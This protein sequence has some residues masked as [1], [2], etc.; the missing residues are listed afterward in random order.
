MTRT[1]LRVAL[2]APL[3]AD[4]AAQLVTLEPRIEIHDQHSTADALFGLPPEG[5]E[6]IAEVVSD[7]PRLRWVHGMASG[8]AAEVRRAGL[9]PAQIDRVRFTTSAGPH[10][11]PL[12]EFALLCLLAGAKD[13]PRLQAQQRRREWAPPWTMTHLAQATVAVVGLGH[14]GRECARAVQ[15]LGARVVGVNRTPRH[16]DGVE[17]VVPLESFADVVPDVDAIVLALPEADGTRHV[18]SRDVLSRMLPGTLVVNVGRGSSV[19]TAALVAALEDGTVGFA[20]LDVV[21][22][23]PLPRDHPLWSLDNVLISPHTAARRDDQTLSIV[24]MFAEN[25]TRLLDGRDLVNE[26]LRDELLGGT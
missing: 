26:V 18:L 4:L 22:P 17:P 12:A 13:L 20:G 7:N 16:V 10:G 5:P 19:D 23:E 24:R 9:T 25:A 14:I 2:A 15:G 21:D 3:D 8:T 6:K 1:P 11:Q